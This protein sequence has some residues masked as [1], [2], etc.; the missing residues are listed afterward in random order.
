[1]AITF[2]CAYYITVPIDGNQKTFY[3]PNV[4]RC[5]TEELFA[6]PYFQSQL[7]IDDDTRLLLISVGIG[8][9][10]VP[11]ADQSSATEIRFF[12]YSKLE[13]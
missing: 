11:S 8:C 10:R 1:V 6:F 7:E 4:V 13:T 12:S 3:R 5:M 9:G 2:F